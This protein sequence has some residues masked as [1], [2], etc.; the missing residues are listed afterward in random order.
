MV[1][2]IGLKIPWFSLSFSDNCTLI[3][4]SPTV[5][6]G[7]LALGRGLRSPSD[8]F[9][10]KTP[11]LRFFTTS[12]CLTPPRPLVREHAPYFKFS[13]LVHSGFS[14]FRYSDWPIRVFPGPTTPR[15]L[16]YFLFASLENYTLKLLRNVCY[17]IQYYT[18]YKPRRSISKPLRL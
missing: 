13:L 4:L 17:N 8:T 3:F 16:K 12:S 6:G 14:S 9:P 11:L 10:N 5:V 2:F 15:F 1:L 18:T 7:I